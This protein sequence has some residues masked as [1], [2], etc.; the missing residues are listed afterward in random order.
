MNRNKVLST[1]FGITELMDVGHAGPSHRPGG[2]LAACAVTQAAFL[3]VA[4][5]R[6]PH[7]SF[8][9]TDD[10]M[11]S[12]VIMNRGFLTGPP[13]DYQHLDGLVTTNPVAPVVSLLKS[14]ERLD[15]QR[16][17]LDVRQPLIE[18]FERWW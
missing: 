3:L 5:G 6:F 4:E 1:Y 9:D 18:L 15:F 7:Q 17:Y 12:V 10:T 13:A 2:T 16:R 14:K 11:R 8:M